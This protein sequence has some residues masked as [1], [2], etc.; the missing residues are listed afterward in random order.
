MKVSLIAGTLK[1]ELIVIDSNKLDSIEGTLASVTPDQV[2]DFLPPGIIVKDFNID[3]E[4]QEV[5]VS[6]NASPS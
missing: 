1:F 3:V 4:S 2:F 6:V 5:E